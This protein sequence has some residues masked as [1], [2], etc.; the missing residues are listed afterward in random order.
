L[1]RPSVEV[2]KSQPQTTETHATP[3]F[4]TLLLTAGETRGADTGSAPALVVPTGTQQVR[5]QLNLRQGGYTNYRIVLQAIGGDTI[6]SWQGIKP[7]AIKSGSTFVITVPA[8]RLASGDYIL[9]L[10]GVR[11]DAEVDDVSKSI[12]RVSKK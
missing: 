4:V 5:I 12:F 7:K 3:A 9:T 8:R 10:R 11:P 6:F 2:R 1:N